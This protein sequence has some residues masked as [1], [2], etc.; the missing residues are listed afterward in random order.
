MKK[1]KRIN[2]TLVLP[3]V[4]IV[5]SYIYYNFNIKSSSY[6]PYSEKPF[7]IEQ[8]Q[9]AEDCQSCHP[10]HYLEWSSSMHAYAFKDPVFFAMNTIEQNYHKDKGEDLGQFCIECHSPVAY[11]TNLIKNPD[12]LTFKNSQKLPDQVTEG[13]G[14][15]FCHAMVHTSDTPNINTKKSLFNV[16][17]YHIDPSNKMYGS[18]S[19]P[20][21][22]NFH[23]SVYNQDF[24]TS[25]ACLPCHNLLIDGKNA[26]ITFSEW[27]SSKYKSNGF[28]CQECHMETYEG[29]AVDPKL[30]PQAKK[31]YNLHRHFFAGIDEA[32]TAFP[33]KDLQRNEIK[34]LL[35]QTANL[36][37]NDLSLI[38]EQNKIKFEVEVFNRAGHNIP[39]GATFARELWLDIKVLS[40]ND[41]IYQTGFVNENNELYDFSI[42]PNK[43]IDPDLVI[44]RSVFYDEKGD[45]GIYKTSAQ[46]M[47][48]KSD[49][50]ISTFESFRKNYT[51]NA[52]NSSDSNFKII[53]KLKFRARSPGFID[54][55][56]L[57]GQVP[58]SDTFIVD[59]KIVEFDSGSQLSMISEE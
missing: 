27:E 7:L 5:I 29:F 9:V 51:I 38:T 47:T 58:Y 1:N 49:Y 17:E 23:E 32:R 35:E 6:S 15:S 8:F 57:K 26:E 40:A 19:D 52:P 41:T 16:V 2:L 14:C 10:Q 4:I 11:T 45:S 18:I 21:P 42:D 54:H 36:N 22:N 44:F 20:L 3:L 43:E 12:E 37:I 34:R 28:P 13:V 46:R 39:S 55:L 25:E 31:R 56:G 53:A 24:S 33:H 30:F 50:T 48:K 59:E